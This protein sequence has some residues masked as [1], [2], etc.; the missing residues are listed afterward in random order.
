MSAGFCS[1]RAADHETAQYPR[2]IPSDHL[3]GSVPVLFVRLGGELELVCTAEA[4]DPML[5][6]MST[7][8]RAQI[9]VVIRA[10][11]A[12]QLFACQDG[13]VCFRPAYAMEHV[14]SEVL[15]D[16][17]RNHPSAQVDPEGS[18]ALD[19]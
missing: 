5:D 11:Q 16:L 8:D 18:H 10:V 17:V 9:R 6:T 3:R 1:S 14:Y 19:S 13:T 2:P 12:H 15:P 7:R 4:N